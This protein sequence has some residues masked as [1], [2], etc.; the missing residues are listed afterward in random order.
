MSEMPPSLGDTV[1]QGTTS[2]AAEEAEIRRLFDAGRT[3]AE[4]VSMRRFRTGSIIWVRKAW[5]RD[6]AAKIGRKA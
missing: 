3:L 2:E 5:E 1:Q 4:V 6:R